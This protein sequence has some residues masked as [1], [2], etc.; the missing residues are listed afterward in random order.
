MTDW[1]VIAASYIG[2]LD[3]V[4]SGCES[5]NDSSRF[6]EPIEVGSL[7]DCLMPAPPTM[8]PHQGGGK[9]LHIKAGLVLRPF[10]SFYNYFIHFAVILIR[11]RITDS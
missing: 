11:Y 9:L 4:S 2:L 6:H 5:I 10:E 7:A 1:I 3:Y 8:E